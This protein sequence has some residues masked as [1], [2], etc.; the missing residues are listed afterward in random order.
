MIESGTK[1]IDIDWVK[2]TIVNASKLEISEELTPEFLK[3]VPDTK[4][5]NDYIKQT[6]IEPTGVKKV[7]NPHLRKTFRQ[8][9]S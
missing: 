2:L 8:F 6:G 3:E 7:P 9:V 5:I 1:E 4:K